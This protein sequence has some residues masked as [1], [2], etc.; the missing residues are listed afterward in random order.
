MASAAEQQSC[1]LR[2]IEAPAQSEAPP[3]PMASSSFG[4]LQEL[5]PRASK[6]YLQHFRREDV[7]KAVAL[8]RLQSQVAPKAPNS[9]KAEARAPKLK[10]ISTPSHSRAN[11][12]LAAK[13]VLSATPHQIH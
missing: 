9:R 8:Q 11:P 2:G 4:K 3:K 5:P 6:A 7:W 12:L 10:P 13:V 1:A